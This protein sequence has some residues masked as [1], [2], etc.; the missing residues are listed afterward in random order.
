MYKSIPGKW[1]ASY[2]IKLREKECHTFTGLSG[3]NE[4]TITSFFT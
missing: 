1:G 4:A 3:W 2:E